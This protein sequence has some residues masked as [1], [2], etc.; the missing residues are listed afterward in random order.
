[1]PDAS[2]LLNQGFVLFLLSFLSLAYEH[3]HQELPY[4]HKCLKSIIAK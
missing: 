3:D 4:V 2:K 1:M